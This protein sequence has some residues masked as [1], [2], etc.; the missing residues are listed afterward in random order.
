MNLRI[1]TPNVLRLRGVVA[2]IALG[3]ASVAAHAALFEDDEAR[4]AVLDLRQRM[5]QSNQQQRDL[6]EQVNQLKRSLLDMN[7]TVEQL[8]ADL[9]KQRGLDEQLQRDVAEIQ[10]KQKDT[11]QTVDDRLRRFEPQKVTLDGKEFMADP[12]E[13]RQYGD[14]IG[15]LRRSDFA[16]AAS[17]LASFQ[18]RYPSSGYNESVLFW[19]GNAQYGKRD[20]REAINAFKGLLAASPD[21]PRA[22]EAMLS[23]ANCQIE[24]KDLKSA[25]RTL[26]D[27][28]KT[29]PQS[30]AA[31][32][33]R[34]RLASL[35]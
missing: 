1:S 16:G 5:E 2:A 32:A 34:E 10:R 6:A 21:S 7:A 29:Y 30:E 15:L 28:V 17:A 24:L 12:D 31:Q 9:A 26:D 20:Y 33:G 14:A 13:T 19:L 35:K 8:R 22:P 11:Q 27:L 25:R 18:K 23:I 3:A 4:R